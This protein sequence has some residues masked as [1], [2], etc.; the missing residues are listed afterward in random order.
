M[1]IVY[2]LGGYDQTK[3]NNNIIEENEIESF[4][5]NKLE[6]KKTAFIEKLKNLGLTEEEIQLII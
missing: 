4:I 6:D 2:G 1:I 5:D 3:P